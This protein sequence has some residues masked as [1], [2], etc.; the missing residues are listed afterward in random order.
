[1]GL[2][3]DRCS[4]SGIEYLT[5]E[6]RSAVTRINR[7]RG[8]SQNFR[9]IPHA[10]SI[11]GHSCEIACSRVIPILF[12]RK[13]EEQLIATVVELGNPDRA[14]KASAKIVLMICRFGHAGNNE[15]VMKAI[16]IQF[17]IAIK[18]ECRAMKTVSARLNRK[19]LHATASPAEFGWNRGRH[20]L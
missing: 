5:L 13:E 9:E 18:L 7:S 10:L 6:N 14:A 16:G 15:V 19:A 2:A 4:G 12:P 1:A 3:T 8:R 20:D 11:G 17:V